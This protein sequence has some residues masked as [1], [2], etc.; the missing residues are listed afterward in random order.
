MVIDGDIVI[1]TTDKITAYRLPEKIVAIGKFRKESSRGAKSRCFMGDN[2]RWYSAE[3][4]SRFLGCGKKTVTDRIHRFGIDAKG[5]LD[6][7]MP[8][9]KDSRGYGS[10]EWRA[11]SD[12]PRDHKI[13]KIPTGKFECDVPCPPA[14]KGKYKHPSEISRPE[15]S[16]RAAYVS[17]R[18]ILAKL[19]MFNAKK[20]VGW[21]YRPE[22]P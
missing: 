4:Y 9:R 20:G 13:S 14:A 17:E 1:Q 11:L 22:V 10:K 3:A 5:I 6:K 8:W 16:E 7:R 19:A 18:R 21:S 12:N 15:Q 2:G